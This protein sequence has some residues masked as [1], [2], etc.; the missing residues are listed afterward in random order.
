MR[1]YVQQMNRAMV[2]PNLSERQDGGIDMILED[3][4]S[5]K[6]DDEK[7]D[8]EVQKKAEAFEEE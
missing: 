6:E 5:M 8:Q 3:D 4:E 7:P 2:M 1:N